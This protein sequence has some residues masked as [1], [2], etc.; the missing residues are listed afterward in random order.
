MTWTTE[1]SE[2]ANAEGWDLF[3]C[4]G[5]DNGPL[6]LCKIDDPEMWREDRKVVIEQTWEEDNEAW[7]FVWTNPSPLHTKALEIIKVEN[8]QEFEAIETWV[9]E[10]V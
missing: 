8:P 6:Q 5:S 7:V 9:S 1:D 2:A 4:D 10:H 3:D